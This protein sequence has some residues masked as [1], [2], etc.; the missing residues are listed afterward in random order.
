MADRGKWL[1]ADLR[2]SK[3]FDAFYNLGILARLPAGIRGCGAIFLLHR[4]AMP[5]SAFLARKDVIST[6]ALE[7]ILQAARELH[8][9]ILRL[10]EVT[11]RLQGKDSGQPFVCFTFDDGYADNLSLALPLFRKYGIPFCVYV[12][13][14]FVSRTHEPWWHV[15]EA[16]AL[17]SDELVFEDSESHEIRLPARTYEEK[18]AAFESASGVL[19]EQK[20]DAYRQL[21]RLRTRYDIPFGSTLDALYC[22]WKQVEE[23]AHDPLVTI[24]NHSVAHSYLPSVSS[25][26]RLEELEHSK[27]VLED[28]LHLTV[29]HFSYPF[30]GYDST[31]MRD[32]AGCGFATSVTTESSNLFPQHRDQP[33]AWPRRTLNVLQDSVAFFRNALFG[34]DHFYR[35]VRRR[36]L[37]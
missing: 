10:D 26:E 25:S 16:A 5:G 31:V 27:S 20:G 32:A 11:A 30:G 21:D 28:R 17:K 6:A 1:S 9:E 19:F 33:M 13:T 8:C 29:R 22:T 12:T 35:W 7:A 15:L 3:A 14:G 2:C 23:L 34:A 24:G 18:V 37:Y 4:V 36:P